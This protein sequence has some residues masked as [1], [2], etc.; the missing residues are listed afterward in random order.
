MTAHRV[1]Q[2]V[3][4]AKTTHP[5]D[6]NVTSFTLTALEHAGR[7]VTLSHTAAASTVTLPAATGSGAV[8]KF[9]VA[10]VNTQ[11]AGLSNPGHRIQVANSTDVFEGT[12]HTI[13]TTDGAGESDAWGSASTDD[14]IT[15]DS[16][17]SGGQAIGDSIEITDYA[18]GKFAVLGFTTTSGTEITPFHANVS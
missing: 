7:I 14:T 11:G 13:S 12:I 17:T 3:M 16:T 18:S 4:L 15:L 10:A 8:Y 2:D 9:I 6:V 5:V 1:L